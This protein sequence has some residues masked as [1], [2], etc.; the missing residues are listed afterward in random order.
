MERALRGTTVARST[1]TKVVAKLGSL[2]GSTPVVTICY[3]PKPMRMCGWNALSAG[4]SPG[5][6]KRLE[7]QAKIG[8]HSRFVRPCQASALFIHTTFI[9]YCKFWWFV[10]IWYH[11]LYD[12][13]IYIYIFLLCYI[14]T[15]PQR[16][17]FSNG[18]KTQRDHFI[19]MHHRSNYK[20]EG[21]IHGVRLLEPSWTIHDKT[22]GL[23]GNQG[24]WFDSHGRF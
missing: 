12:Y 13:I 14:L 19:P 8:T 6:K 24:R 20:T 3:F 18:S 16:T 9:T 21:N 4:L 7:A 5:S 17:S 23:R 22:R 15:Q 11:I 1:F 10:L 2:A